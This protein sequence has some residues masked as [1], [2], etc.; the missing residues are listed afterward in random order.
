MKKLAELDKLTLLDVTNNKLSCFQDICTN[1]KLR[2]L[3]LQY[4]EIKSFPKGLSNLTNLIEL[5]LSFNNIE[6][7]TK[8]IFA[9]KR[10]SIFWIDSNR[11][12]NIWPDEDEKLDL[13]QKEPVRR[14]TREGS[15]LILRDSEEIV[16]DNNT[17]VI[18]TPLNSSTSNIKIK[19]SENTMEEKTESTSLSELESV[20][21]IYENTKE[22]NNN[23]S[24]GMIISDFSAYGNKITFIPHSFFKSLN[25]N[26]QNLNLASNEIADFPPSFKLCTIL[27]KLNLGYNKFRK[28]PSFLSDLNLIELS[29]P[30]N[31]I[32]SFEDSESKKLSV[33]FC[34]CF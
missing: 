8:E 3:R 10:M 4:N 27:K 29:V 6:Y 22:I 32:K 20:L 11:L 2:I 16:N 13:L 21:K 15:L 5:D 7:I 1:T 14:P 26:L 17:F 18:E 23:L 9:L 24:E 30:C 28:F 33:K 31:R 34:F 19:S 25:T 12:K